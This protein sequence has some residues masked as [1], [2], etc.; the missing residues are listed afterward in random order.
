ML[1]FLL[2]PLL[3]DSTFRGSLKFL[4]VTVIV[5]FKQETPYCLD[6]SG[7]SLSNQTSHVKREYLKRS[8]AQ[9]RRDK[10]MVDIETS[11]ILGDKSV[12]GKAG[13]QTLTRKG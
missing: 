6:T 3:V 1:I 4:A 13:K 12:I 9:E 7:V 10:E 11:V 5:T 8:R 2:S